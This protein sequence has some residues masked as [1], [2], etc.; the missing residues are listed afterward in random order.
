MHSNHFRAEPFWWQEAPLAESTGIKTTRLPNNIDVMV[1]GSGYTGLH[2]A[3]QTTR[4]G[5]STLV[6][7]AEALGNGCSSR[8]GGQVSTSI[9]GDY[10][11]LVRRYGSDKALAMSREG[12]L[13][14]D[15]LEQFIKEEEIQNTPE[16]EE[17]RSS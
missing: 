12:I 13:A 15:F 14:V 3:L 16:P 6:V 11:E 10:K 17:V 8:N 1:V 4:A 2:A 7:D 5:F 9:K